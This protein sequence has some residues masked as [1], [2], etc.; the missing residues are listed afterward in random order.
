MLKRKTRQQ[1]VPEPQRQLA[2]Y[3]DNE[4]SDGIE[5]A[6]RQT[7]NRGAGFWAAMKELGGLIREQARRVAAKG[8]Q[9]GE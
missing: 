4:L 5:S 6:M 9:H 3:A 1:R 8:K 7:E 2:D